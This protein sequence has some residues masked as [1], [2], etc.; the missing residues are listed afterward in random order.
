MINEV[1]RA[2]TSLTYGIAKWRTSLE[3]SYNR[4]FYGDLDID[5]GKAANIKSVDG[6]RVHAVVM[7]IF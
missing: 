1:G 3:Y 5:K 2:S 6:G 7:L 4:A